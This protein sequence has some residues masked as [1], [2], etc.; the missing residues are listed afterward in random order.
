MKPL[1][2]IKNHKIVYDGSD[3]QLIVPF[4]FSALKQLVP[5]FDADGGSWIQNRIKGGD[6][7]A[8]VFK[9]NKSVHPVTILL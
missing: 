3:G 4:N 5:W 8:Y 9:T 2:E 7:F 1:T 6:G